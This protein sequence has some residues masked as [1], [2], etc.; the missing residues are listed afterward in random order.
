MWSRHGSGDED[1]M[2]FI[3]PIP[4]EEALQSRS[5]KQPSARTLRTR[6]LEQDA[7]SVVQ[8]IGSTGAALI[9]VAEDEDTPAHYLSGLRSALQRG[10]H[11]EILLQK[12]RGQAQIVARKALPDDAAR[13]Q[14][15]RETG[16]RL[17]QMAKERAATASGRRRGRK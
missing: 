4:L 11:A 9:S 12:K 6:R 17:G 13:L 2:A 8:A 10:G 14:K 5:S 1:T 15:R 16:A 3:T 7:E